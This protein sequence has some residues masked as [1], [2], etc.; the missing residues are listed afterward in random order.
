MSVAWAADPQPLKTPRDVLLLLGQSPARL[1][2]SADAVEQVLVPLALQFDAQVL[3]SLPRS[4][5]LEL[6]VNPLLVNARGATAVDA[7]IRLAHA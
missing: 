2:L 6:D 5:L 1:R 7:L 4:Q 3:P